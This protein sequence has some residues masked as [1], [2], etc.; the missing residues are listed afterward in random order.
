MLKRALFS[1][2]SGFVFPAITA[3][4]FFLFFEKALKLCLSYVFLISLNHRHFDYGLI[5]A[6]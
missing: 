1:M 5:S 3:K 2:F 6:D 4:K